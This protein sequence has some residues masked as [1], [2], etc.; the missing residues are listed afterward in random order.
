MPSPTPAPSYFQ[1]LILL[2]HQYQQQQQQQ[3]QQQRQQLQSQQQQLHQQQNQNQQHAHYDQALAH[4]SLQQQQSM[5]PVGQYTDQHTQV[6]MLLAAQKIK[7]RHVPPLPSFE[8]FGF[9]PDDFLTRHGEDEHMVGEEEEKEE[10]E[11]KRTRAERQ[12]G[13][14]AEEEQEQ[15]GQHMRGVHSRSSSDL[16]N[17]H[18]N[19]GIGAIDDRD[20]KDDRNWVRVLDQKRQERERGHGQAGNNRDLDN[21][22]SNNKSSEEDQDERE[23]GSQLSAETE[24]ETETQRQRCRQGQKCVKDEE[25]ADGVSVVG[26][27]QTN[28]IAQKKQH[29]QAASSHATESPAHAVTG[30]EGDTP[31]SGAEGVEPD[32][33]VTASGN[34]FSGNSNGNATQPSQPPPAIGHG[35][36]KQE[37]RQRQQQ[38]LGCQR[39]G[40]EKRHHGHASRGHYSQSDITDLKTRASHPPIEGSMLDGD[41]SPGDTYSV[42]AAASP[43]FLRPLRLDLDLQTLSALSLS[44][45]SPLSARSNSGGSK[46][47]DK[48]NDKDKSVLSSKTFS[49]HSRPGHQ[50]RSSRNTN[51][52]EAGSASSAPSA[53]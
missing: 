12:D 2:Q 34:L 35:Q 22:N 31:T 33:A 47:K 42:A 14:K 15:K 18:T 39:Y 49:S 37:Q 27:A 36:D 24:T 46:G 10:E 1:S 32:P 4:L 26:V 20:D 16:S 30:P 43:P 8:P 44:S 6:Q 5:V 53:R 17:K 38:G 29:L 52:A 3:Q 11:E 19:C 51:G 21:N 23:E 13:G 25:D 40:R 41:T 50:R 45:P 7:V 28:S 9:G 48:V